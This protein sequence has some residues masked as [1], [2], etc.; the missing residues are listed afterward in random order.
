MKART[1]AIGI[2]LALFV[3]L[4]VGAVVILDAVVDQPPPQGTR[5]K[6]PHGA[7]GVFAGQSYAWIVPVDEQRVVL[8]DAGTDPDA[9]ALRA[10]LAGREV[11]ATLLTHGHTDHLQG[12]GALPQVP[13]VHGPGEG[14][15]VRGE[16]LPGGFLAAW[17]SRTLDPPPLPDDVREVADGEVLAFGPRRFRVVHLPGHTSGSV[18]Y[19]WRDVL[20][21]GDALL[22]GAQ[23]HMAPEAFATDP[24]EAEGSVRRLAA[25]DF[26][27]IADGHVG[28]RG[29]AR[30]ALFT[31]LDE[32]M[33]EATIAIDD[34]EPG[35]PASTAEPERVEALT[36]RYVQTPVPDARGLQP[37]YLVDE[38]GERWVISESPVGEHASLR[39]RQVTV[40]GRVRSPSLGHRALAGP[41]L[42]LEA[43]EATDDCPAGV[44]RVAPET[45]DAHDQAWVEVV[46]PLS[47]LVPL[48]EGAVQ[49]EGRLGEVSLYAPARARAW[50]GTTITVLAR[51]DGDA[52]LAV[53]VCPGD[54]PGCGR[55]PPDEPAD[56]ALR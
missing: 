21:T 43:I 36:G 16:R 8:I 40:S 32:P 11:M 13:L 5:L 42:E 46:G 45:L 56:P 31:L 29:E 22:G 48:S 44:L 18:A 4:L 1:V 28:L 14:T 50:V 19:L 35:P 12:I 55:L 3:P 23:L 37:A 9:T 30:Q 26:A 39:Q 33:A 10:E 2:L 49:A 27:W 47:S 41:W 53:E 15:L 24:E 6:G 34:V 25:V 38:R 7:I 20:F 51:V 54:V 52:L 17:L